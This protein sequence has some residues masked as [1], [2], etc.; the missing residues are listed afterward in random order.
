[1]DHINEL[2]D[3]EYQYAEDKVSDGVSGVERFVWRGLSC[4][5]PGRR[6]ANR[7]WMRTDS[8]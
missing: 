6:P 2:V 5:R 8:T 1:M 4:G 3:P 7:T